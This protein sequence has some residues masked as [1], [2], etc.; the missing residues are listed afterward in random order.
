ML[1]WITFGLTRALLISASAS[2]YQSNL[3]SSLRLLVREQLNPAGTMDSR[4]P[5]SFE[6]GC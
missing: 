5:A 4:Y 1:V 6:K 2:D 3:S